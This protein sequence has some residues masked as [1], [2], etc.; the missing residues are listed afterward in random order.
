MNNKYRPS[1]S[2]YEMRKL[3]LM[4]KAREEILTEHIDSLK[5]DILEHPDDKTLDMNLLF[6][7]EDEVERKAI[8]KVMAQLKFSIEDITGEV[9]K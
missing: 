2:V 9:E 6:I 7:E 5:K 4:L 1:Q 8:W 3:R